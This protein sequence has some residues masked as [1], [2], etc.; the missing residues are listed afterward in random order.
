MARRAKRPTDQ[1]FE[2]AIMWLHVNDGANGESHACNAVADW[3]EHWRN[4][5]MLKKT[6]REAG[7]SVSLVRSRLAGKANAEPEMKN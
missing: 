2:T 4:D 6:A 1:Q 3:I 5:D 7:I